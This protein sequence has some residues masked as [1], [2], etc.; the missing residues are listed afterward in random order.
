LDGNHYYGLAFHLQWKKWREKFAVTFFIDKKRE[1]ARLLWGLKNESEKMLLNE[2]L[3]R[4]KEKYSINEIE[5]ENYLTDKLEGFTNN[6]WRAFLYVRKGE[7]RKIVNIEGGEAIDLF[8]RNEDINQIE[9]IISNWA[10]KASYYKYELG[11]EE[12]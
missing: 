6:F 3:Y 5:S 9:P 2:K 12:E 7:I 1:F 10:E 4:F 8:V 11:Q